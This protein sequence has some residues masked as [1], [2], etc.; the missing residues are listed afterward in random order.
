MKIRKLLWIDGIAALVAGLAVLC[1]RGSLSELFQ[2]PERIL[3]VQAI[4]T[5]VYTCYST[6]L[7]QNKIYTKRLTRIL[8]IANFT[9]VVFCL[10]LFMS[11]FGETN[12]LGKVYFILE[13]LFISTLATLESRQLKYVK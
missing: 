4:I 1:L 6:T 3:L 13:A 9:Y 8:V 12:V 2:L 7:A 11:T 10:G 5:L